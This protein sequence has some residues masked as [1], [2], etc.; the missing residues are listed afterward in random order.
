[1]RTPLISVII[2]VYRAENFLS[3]CLDSLINQTFTDWE[4]ILVDDGSPDKSGEI[5]EEYALRDSR[6]RVF[7]KENGGV[8]SARN[9]G[10]DNICGEFVTFIDSDD[11]VGPTYLSLFAEHSNFDLIFTGLHRVG[12]VDQVWF[13]EEE[14][15]FPS[16][17]DLA[18]AWM[19]NFE[20][21]HLTLGGLNFV[22]C[23]ALRS[24][25]IIEHK[26]RFDPQM[27][28]GEDT[29][30]VYEWM[31]FG[32]NAIQVKGNEYYYYTPEGGHNFKMSLMQYQSHCF[33]YQKHIENI[34]DKFDAFSQR[35]LD[36]Y[37][38]STFGTYYQ[39]FF[40]AQLDYVL[41]ESRKFRVQNKYPVFDSIRREKGK[42]AAWSVKQSFQFP[43]F[44]YIV[45][46]FRMLYLLFRKALRII[47]KRK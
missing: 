11:Y 30:F 29:C 37:V 20:K 41:T 33:I 25:Y 16:M 12:S 5:C 34:R 2:P 47:L 8:S 35:Q 17:K 13:G 15:E 38:D 6:F 27:K 26:L 32:K 44:F 43:L 39:T 22:A 9:L 21:K 46:R 19:D 18:S 42:L 7:H 31:M 40:N 23:K 3:K 10:L 36:S 14:Q 4:C 24:K 1:M 45:L 28:K